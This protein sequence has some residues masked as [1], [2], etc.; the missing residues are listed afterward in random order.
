LIPRNSW[1]GRSG[2]RGIV[3]VGVSSIQVW[4][5]GTGSKPASR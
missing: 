2:A 3:I 4:H 5:P 1:L